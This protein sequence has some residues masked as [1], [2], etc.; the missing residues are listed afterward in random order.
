MASE[1]KV[2]ITKWGGI[3]VVGECPSWDAYSAFTTKV[4]K[5]IGGITKSIDEIHSSLIQSN[6][7]L[8]ELEAE[9]GKRLDQIQQHLK[10]LSD[11][12]NNLQAALDKLKPLN[13]AQD[14]KEIISTQVER[15]RS[16]ALDIEQKSN[17]CEERISNIQDSARADH[18][19]LVQQI[20][21]GIE[22]VENYSET[23]SKSAEQCEKLRIQAEK[24][25][26]H[27]LSAMMKAA[28]EQTAGIVDKISE[29][30]KSGAS[31]HS[32]LETLAQEAAA[33]TALART[34]VGEMEV[35]LDTVLRENSNSI[36]TAQ[37]IR[38]LNQRSWGAL[39][40]RLAWLLL[41]ASR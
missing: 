21:A 24:E 10:V 6:D 3:E 1:N 11:F 39:W 17:H 22:H 15:F 13:I 2:V 7:A 26:Q 40:K 9:G 19:C 23:S 37:L 34:I 32:K 16:I 27:A 18:E 31:F 14:L 33:T 41:G 28:E 35:R 30:E 38:A 12:Q 5:E 36:E 20:N 25:S 4:K 29:F 8:H